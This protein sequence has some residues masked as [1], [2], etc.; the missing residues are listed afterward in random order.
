MSG[1]GAGGRMR[2]C[3]RRLENMGTSQVSMNSE[4][5]IW[6]RL[7]GT[8]QVA[9]APDVARYFLSM[10]FSEADHARMQELVDK[11]SEGTL[12]DDEAAE[13]NGYV[14][15]ANVLAVMHSRSRVALRNA[16]FE[17]SDGNCNS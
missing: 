16:G 10:K 2:E 11:S 15:V 12:T 5:A 7:I 14:N 6:A 17:P 3:W 1:S 8:P 13:L 9:I 4:T